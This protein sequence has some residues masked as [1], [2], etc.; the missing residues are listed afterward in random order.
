MTGKVYILGGAQ[1]DFARNWQREG[2]EIFDLMREVVLTGLEAT[3]LAPADL[4]AAHIG[5]FAAELFCHQGQLGGLFA[6]I[7]PEF[8]GLPTTR[9]EAACASGSTAILA[10]AADIEAGRYELVCVL[11]V[12]LMRNVPGEQMARHLGTA[13]W[14]GR[15][16]NDAA[17]VW[18]RAFSELMDEYGRRYG[19]DYRYIARIAEINFANGRRNPNA[20]TRDW[21]FTERSFTTDPEQNPVVDGHTRRNDCGQVTDGATVLF[22]ASEAFARSYLSSRGL[23]AAQLATIRGW[24]HRTATMRLSDKLAES[25]GA[26]HVLPQV[27]ACIQ[28]AFRRAEIP[29]IEAVDCIETHDCFAMTE[30]MAIDHFGIT[31][32]GQSWRAVDSGEIELGGRIPINPSGGLIGLGHPVGATGVRMALDSWRQVTG[33]AGSYQVEGAR[34]AATLNIGGSTT[35]IVSL[36]IGQTE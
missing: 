22:L 13:A 25:A 1:S 23:P 28:D 19:I 20:Q 2:H 5:N 16:F 30:Y 9:H 6:S 3:H 34:T 14:Y 8:R 7:A 15:E 11:G 32:P 31:A 27:H 29:G 26:P 21:K 36:M 17:Y 24:G 18:P 4:Q 33:T 12:E 10:A 35:S